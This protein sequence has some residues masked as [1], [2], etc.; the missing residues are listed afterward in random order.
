MALLAGRK[1]E[2]VLFAEFYTDSRSV[3][4]GFFPDTTY[5]YGLLDGKDEQPDYSDIRP[6]YA[7]VWAGYMG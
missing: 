4:W 1:M 6:M 2:E 7:W 3:M 5:Y